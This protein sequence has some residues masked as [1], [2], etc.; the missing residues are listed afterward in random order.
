VGSPG[1]IAP[2]F[3]LWLTATGFAESA[4]ALPQAIP[5]TAQQAAAQGLIHN[6]YGKEFLKDAPADRL[7]L[8][9]TLLSQAQQSRDDAAA[10]YVALVDAADVAGAAG[11]VAT[12]W[13]AIDLLAQGYLVNALEL[14]RA[15]LAH[16]LA[17]ARSAP[18]CQAI[19]VAAL[20]TADQ[21]AAVDAF[22]AV[23]QLATLAENAANQAHDLKTVVSIQTRLADLRSLADEFTKV[24]AAFTQLEIN[25]ADPDAHLAIGRFYALQ[26]NQWSLG[27]MHLAAGSDPT[28]QSLAAQEL[29]H[30]TD[31]LALAQLGDAWWAYGE[32]ATG[33]LRRNAQAHAAELYKNAQQN[34]TGTTLARLQ[35]RITEAGGAGA[36]AA[37]VPS[38]PETG[39]SIDLLALIDT[40]KDAQQGTWSKATGAITCD[41]FSYATLALPYAPPEEY[42]LVTTFTRTDGKGPIAILLAAGKHSFDFS[43][44][45]KGEARFERVAGKIAKDNPTTTPVAITNNHA[46]R[47]TIEVRKDRIRALLDGKPLAEY[48]TDGKDLSRYNSW[49]LKD[50]SLCGLGANNAKVTF[51]SIQLIE[52]TGKGKPAR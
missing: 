19:M 26:K 25:P 22:D 36:A 17:N 51:Q 39:A 27:L 23:R 16:A 52:I 46:Y 31:G 2:L 41:P 29:V 13:A 5:S 14:R 21:A 44:D 35:S 24:R 48:K 10:R 8:A 6:L 18:Q 30:P 45:I 38:A 47:L 15:A 7:A 37:T 49:K 43:L 3:L 4:P 40:A 42:D 12:A 1:K 50:E 28:L 11:D 34:I 33:A 20:E 9:K 32:K